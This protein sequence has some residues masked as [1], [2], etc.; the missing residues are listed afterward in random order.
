MFWDLLGPSQNAQIWTVHKHFF[1]H[2]DPFHASTII[3]TE[4]F[5][6]FKIK[7][8]RVNDLVGE[9]SFNTSESSETA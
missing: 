8:L 3:L 6:L 5:M 7:K 4:Y 2:Q 1:C 9:N